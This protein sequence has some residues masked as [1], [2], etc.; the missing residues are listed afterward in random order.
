VKRP[1]SIP[2]KRP[3]ALKSPQGLPTSYFHGRI[4][5]VA[6]RYLTEQ[7]LRLGYSK[8]RT[9]SIILLEHRMARMRPPEKS[10]P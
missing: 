3:R 7:A 9:L 10:A 4:E 1:R 6:D 5:A 2:R 8:A